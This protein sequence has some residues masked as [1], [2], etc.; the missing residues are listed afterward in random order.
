MKT[1]SESRLVQIVENLPVP[2]Q[3][4]QPRPDLEPFVQEV[5]ANYP[6]VTC[7]VDEDGWGISLTGDP[8]LLARIEDETD[9]DGTD[10]DFAAV[11]GV[12]MVPGPHGD[13]L[14]VDLY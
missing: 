12:T 5:T 1:P 4:G 3:A 6:G 13:T 2:S 11:E 8:A 10:L 9:W 7:T 14:Y